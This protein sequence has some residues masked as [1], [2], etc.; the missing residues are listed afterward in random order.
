MARTFVGRIVFAGAVRQAVRPRREAEHRAAARHLATSGRRTTSRSTIK[1]RHGVTFHDGEKFDAAAVKYNLERHKN[2]KGSNRRGELAVVSSVDVVDPSTV[3]I[4]LAAPF[5][6]LLAV[7]TDRAGHDGVAQGG[8][9]RGRQVRRQAGVL[10]AVQVRR[11]HRAGPHRARALPELLEQG[12]DPLRAHRLPADRR[13]H[14]APRQPA[15]GPARLHRAHGALRRAAA[16]G[17]TAASRSPRSSRSATRASPSTSARA[18]SRR[19]TRSA[20]TRACARRSSC[21]STA[22]RI[23]KVAMDGEAQPGNQ[24]VA[25]TNRYYG[26]SAPMPEAR[27]RR[28]RSSC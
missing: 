6:P 26:K 4:N 16:A 27:R 18:T 1:L 28:A 3:R 25:P 24:W 7:L 11:A 5:A 17:A 13:R 10:R 14:G 15:L 22:T 9:G 19:R 21:R 2:M 8:G 20:R 12:P 23:V